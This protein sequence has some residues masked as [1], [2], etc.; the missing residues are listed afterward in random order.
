MGTRG[1][2]WRHRMRMRGRRRMRHRLVN[3]PGLV[4]PAVKPSSY[5]AQP[6]SSVTGN[7]AAALRRVL[8]FMALILESENQ[9]GSEDHS[10]GKGVSFVTHFV[11][12]R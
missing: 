4:I 3:H 6:E 7:A 1:R 11:S 2:R 10:R 12:D 9:F 8:R 5:T